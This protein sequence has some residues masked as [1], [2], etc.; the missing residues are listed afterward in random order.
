MNTMTPGSPDAAQAQA[1][2]DQA[3]Q[4]GSSVRSGA[5]WPAISFLLG[6]GAL[7]S[8]GI[9]TFT[10]ARLVADASPTLPAILMGVWLLILF[11]TVLFFTRTSKRGFGR[12]WGIYMGLWGALWM[13]GML[14]SGFVFPGELWFAGVVAASLTVS[15]TSCAWYE[16]T[17]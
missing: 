14:L 2:L 13:A 3:G 8:M 11:G 9:L 6:L 7:S 15:T 17:R 12:R 4:V 5:S 10:Y 16:A 1:L